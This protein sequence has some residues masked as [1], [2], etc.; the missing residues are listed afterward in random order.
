MVIVVNDPNGTTGCGPYTVTVN[1]LGGACGPTD[2][3]VAT[4]TPGGP[5]ATPTCVAGTGS[6]AA[7]PD[8]PFPLV[9]SVGVYFPDGNFYSMGG[10]QSDAAGSDQLN[11]LEYNT[12]TNT[13][14]VKSATYNDAQVNNQACGVLTMG[15]TPYIICVGGSQ[16]GNTTASA[17]VRQYDP[18]TD[19]LTAWATD[20]WPGNSSGTILPGGFAVVNNKLYILGGFDINVAATNQIWELDPNAAAGSRW[21]QKV[22]APGVLMYAP[23]AAIGGKIY[24]GG[25]SD[26]QGGTVVDTNLSFSYDPSTNTIGTISTIPRA[27]GETRG[28]VVGGQMWVLGGGRVAPNPSNEVDVYDPGTD[29]WSV[30]APFVNP[31]RNFAADSDP[32][33]GRVWLAGGYDASGVNPITSMEIFT[34]AAPCNTPVAT[35]TPGNVAS[36]RHACRYRHTRRSHGYTGSYRHTRRTYRHTYRN[37]N[38]HP[39]HSY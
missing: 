3:P 25:A 29:T 24:V 28:V 16:A 7:G 9:R 6:W 5:T 14:S 21:T 10:R 37:S 20:N 18:A 27:T 39:T 11:P 30:G 2:T 4:D 22:N 23:A 36:Y 35:D 13:W 17:Q 15:G 1:G 26:Y 33:T 8:L 12:S 34:P 38:R 31:R 19:T 32:A